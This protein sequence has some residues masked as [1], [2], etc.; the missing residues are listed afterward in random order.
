MVLFSKM[1]LCIILK[2]LKVG[3]YQNIERF[4]EISCLNVKANSSYLAD[5]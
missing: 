3:Q 2:H 4:V 1:L 5:T